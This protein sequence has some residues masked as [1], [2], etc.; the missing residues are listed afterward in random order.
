MTKARTPAGTGAGTGTGSEYL[1]DA[2]QLPTARVFDEVPGLSNSMND[3]LEHYEITDGTLF[4]G[5]V[6]ATSADFVFN[7]TAKDSGRIMGI[8][9]KTGAVAMDGSVGWELPFINI[10]QSNASCAFFGLGSGTEA[11]KGTDNDVA[12]AAGAQVYI[13]NS[14]VYNKPGFR[15]SKHSIQL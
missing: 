15:Y 9:Y 13:S 2:T 14:I 5:T 10:S 11:A 4:S 1:A 8:A 3:M 12:V 7:F 6:Q